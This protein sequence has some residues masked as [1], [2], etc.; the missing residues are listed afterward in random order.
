MLNLSRDIKVRITN[1]SWPII[2]FI[3]LGLIL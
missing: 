2:F 1:L 3:S